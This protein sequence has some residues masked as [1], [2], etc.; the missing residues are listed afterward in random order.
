MTL[1]ET[2]AMLEEKLVSQLAGQG[3]ERV[4]IKDEYQLNENFKKQLGKHN[5]IEFSEN[6]FK[7]IKQYLDKPVTIYEKAK[8]IRDKVNI[9]LDNGDKKYIEFFN[10]EKWCQ[11]RFQV[12]NQITMVNPKNNITNRYDVTLL[13]NGLPL[14]QIELKRRGM[15][16]KTAY[17]QTIRYNEHTMHNFFGFIQLY[18]ISN[19]V[20]TKYYANNRELEKLWKQ[21]FDWTDIKNKPITNLDEFAESFLEKCHLAKMIIKYIV[22]NTSQKCL[23]ILRPY[24]YFAVEKILEQVENSNKNG[25]IWHTTGSGKTLTSFKVS[26]IL[27]EHPDVFK[28][29]FVVDR[30][31]LDYQTQ[32]EFNSFEPGSVDGTSNTDQLVKHLSDPNRPLLITTIQKMALFNF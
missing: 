29:L 15:D 3:Y 1:R 26:Q 32:K 14:V 6:E 30:N 11:N 5:G 17:N 10:S 24:Q 25:Y 4:I 20:N 31:D 2:E 21:T 18:V 8:A 28:V 19:G 12:S 23:M 16:I 13:I 7:Q 22:L 9:E 27:R